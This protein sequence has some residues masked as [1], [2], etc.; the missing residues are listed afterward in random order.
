MFNQ[1]NYYF[2]HDPNFMKTLK[3]KIY[4]NLLKLLCIKCTQNLIISYNDLQCFKLI[5]FITVPSINLFMIYSL[6]L[7]HKR[8]QRGII[9]YKQDE[10]RF[11]A[12]FFILEK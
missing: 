2:K 7:M 11:Y 1:I 6:K 5:N 8:L 4:F 3:N 12:S 9:N 10:K